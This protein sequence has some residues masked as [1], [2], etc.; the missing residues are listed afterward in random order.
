MPA[1]DRTRTWLLALAAG[2]WSVW[3]L[4]S[5]APAA[6]IVALVASVAGR[7]GL[8]KDALVGV[9]V[10]L[11]VVGLSAWLAFRLARRLDPPRA[12]WLAGPAGYLA[13]YVVW[14]ALVRLVGDTVTGVDGPSFLRLAASMAVAAAGAYLGLSTGGAGGADA[15]NGRRTPGSPG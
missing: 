1:R 15:G 10:E 14:V 2:V 6:Y 13:S 8:L 12:F 11:V 5:V 9:A 3:C 7:P 4:L